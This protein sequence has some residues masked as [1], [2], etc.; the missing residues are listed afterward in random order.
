M[1]KNILFIAIIATL[2]CLVACSSKPAG[3]LTDFDEAKKIANR[4][5]KNLLIFFSGEDWDGVS[6]DLKTNILTTPEFMTVVEEDYVL[7]QID[8]SNVAYESTE[9]PEDA[10]EEEKAAAQAILADLEKKSEIASNFSVNTMPAILLTT[11]DGYIFSSL[12]NDPNTTRE[13]YLEKIANAKE[14]GN[15]IRE[16]SKKVKSSR[17]VKKVTA[18]N[19]L[20]EALEP[21][22]RYL[23]GDLISQTLELDPE[24]KSGVMD[25]F[26]IH[27][28]NAKAMTKFMQGDFE[29]G[30]A[31][32]KAP[33]ET[34]FLSIEQKQEIYYQIAYLYA[35]MLGPDYNET[36]MENLET[37][38]NLD[39]TT[40]IAATMKHT[41]DIYKTQVLQSE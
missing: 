15:N 6:T 12:Y 38:Y 16:L 25:K 24:N 20:Y 41:I 30:I 39:T 27:D 11:K 14:T 35:T 4:Q 22:Y 3:W 34:T 32:L 10:T 7:V 28:S 31:E 37:G 9:V 2:F 21:S 23:L 26:S 5:D 17:G 19:N 40:E 36:V 33:L 13:E 29:A 8:I 18:I 1:K